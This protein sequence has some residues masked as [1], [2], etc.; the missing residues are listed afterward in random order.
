LGNKAG[1][2]KV[3]YI[4]LFLLCFSPCVSLAEEPVLDDL[5]PQ[6]SEVFTYVYEDYEVAYDHIFSEEAIPYWWA[7]GLSTVALLAVDDK[8]ILEAKRWGRKNNISD[9]D[10]IET[11]AEY[12]GVAL[13]RTPT[14][15]G[16]ALYFIGDGWTHAG[17]AAGFMMTGAWTDD[18]KTSSVG[19]QIAEGMITTTIATQ[20]LKHITG[21][22]TPNRA[23][24]PRGRWDFFPNQRDY[25]NCVPCYDAFPSGHLAVGTMTLTVIS[26]NYPDNPWI[27]P[28]GVTLLSLLSF[29][30][31]N[32]GV[33]WA[34]DYPVA[35]A[36]GYTFGN[37]AYERGQRALARG[38]EVSNMQWI[39]LV[40]QNDVGVGMQYQF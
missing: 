36:L 27:M 16:S 22:E 6:V 30:M 19:Y 11:Q 3:K 40:G 18:T 9:G 1:Q 7:V 34:S 35:I 2:I 5:Y 28:T 23:T 13:F 15:L 32:N 14:D 25:A 29:Q 38:E 31:M 12:K 8:L 26:K 17:I 39:P 24:T 4:A 21:H 37:I 20:A 10:T 33:H